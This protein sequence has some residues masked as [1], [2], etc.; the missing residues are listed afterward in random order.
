MIAAG[1]WIIDHSVQSGV[2]ILVL[3]VLSYLFP[4]L[5]KG[6]FYVLWI[7]VFIRL[8]LPIDIISPLGVVPDIS[9][10]QLAGEG[11]AKIQAQLE[12]HSETAA[13]S[14]DIGVGDGE[15]KNASD[16]IEGMNSAGRT[17]ENHTASDRDAAEKN[18]AGVVFA[19][20]LL[21]I[22]I[23]GALVMM[24][25]SFFCY[26][27]LKQK[28]RDRRPLELLGMKEK[29]YVSDRIDVPFV[30]GVWR[31]EIYVPELSFRPY[32]YQCILLHEQTHMKRHDP[33]IKFSAYLVLCLHWF[34]PLVWV[35]YRQLERSMEFSC[36][37]SVI[38]RLGETEKKVYSRVLLSVAA[39]GQERKDGGIQEKSVLQMGF[40]EQ[41]IRRR[42][43]NILQY[44]S[45][46]RTVTVFGAMIVISLGICILSTYAGREDASAVRKE[47]SVA[48]GGQVQDS[49]E[50]AEKFF[51]LAP[52]ED[53][54]FTRNMTEYPE[55]VIT[56]LSKW[57]QS[58]GSYDFPQ[59]A[60][61]AFAQYGVGAVTSLQL[62]EELL[63][64]ISTED[65]YLLMC[66]NPLLFIYNAYDQS[67]V[68]WDY[69]SDQFNGVYELACREDADGI[70]GRCYEAEVDTFGVLGFPVALHLSAD[71]TMSDQDK[72]VYAF[73]MMLKDALDAL[74]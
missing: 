41:D 56:D 73:T 51:T 36:D 4:K 59:E 3:L 63:A 16:G 24:W 54:S 64:E 67:Y 9:A 69:F 26:Y 5:P 18:G 20:I 7:M 11:I 29:A 25:H 39:G 44:R 66:N 43:S 38:R 47:A 33:K 13:S 71:K 48:V 58:D 10:V 62:P 14:S 15:W 74:H 60:Y 49:V 37:E 50:D 45:K 2:I 53:T 35:A 68:M 42:I 21:S 23:L 1:L 34:N 65:L 12:S 61:E 57:R 6:Y 27:R 22:W 19:Y 30:L 17:A 8:V 52:K 28:L 32:E 46:S 40:L 55:E 72:Q 31:P 70:V